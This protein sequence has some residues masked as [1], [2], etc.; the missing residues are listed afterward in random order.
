MSLK[1]GLSWYFFSIYC[2]IGLGLS[3]CEFDELTIDSNAG[4]EQGAGRWWNKR[5]Y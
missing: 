2:C 5:R 3:A 1:S 4:E